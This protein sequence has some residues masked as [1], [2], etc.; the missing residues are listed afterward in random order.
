MDKRYVHH[1]WT[2]AR[3][4][5]PLYFLAIAVASGVVCV[6]ALRANNLEMARL[7]DAV[8]AADKNNGNVQKALQDLQV[9]VTSHMNTDLATGPNSPYP[10]IQL[11]YTYD[12]LVTA[13]GEAASA[14]NA[15]IYTD[16]QAYC[17][18]QN[19]KDFSGRN[20]VPCIQ[21]YVLSHGVNLPN[22]PD[23]MYKFNFLSPIWSPDLAGWSMIASGLSLILCV[24]SW[25]LEHWLKMSSR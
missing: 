19:S 24:G 1:L 13:A 6:F 7:R 10:P 5:K 9:Y 14:A 22:I 20:R 4:I 16:A 21:Q 8:Y 23:A 2:Q 17:E 11:Q 3:A 25:L 12:R 15:K 18:Q